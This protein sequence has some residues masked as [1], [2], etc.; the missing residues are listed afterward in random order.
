MPADSYDTIIV[1]AGILGL[2]V[3]RALLARHGPAGAGPRVLVVERE[4]AVARH[5][6]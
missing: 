5:Q 3:A 2:A 4:D 1:G 6:T